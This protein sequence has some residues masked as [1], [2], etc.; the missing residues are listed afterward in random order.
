M[1]LND[2]RNAQDLKRQLPEITGDIKEKLRRY[3][4]GF[5]IV[6]NSLKDTRFSV[7]FSVQSTNGN[8]DVDLLPTF[9][10]EGK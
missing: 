4:R 2:V 7:K 1:I 3:P 5:T 8:I 9:K 10:F 6:P